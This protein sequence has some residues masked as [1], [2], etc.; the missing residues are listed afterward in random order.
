MNMKIQQGSTLII[1]L[2]VLLLV[3]IVG[4]IAVKS[5]TLGLRLATNN[6]LGQ[7]LMEMND[8]G[9][10]TLENPDP[11]YIE[12]QIAQGGMYSYFNNPS[13]ARNELV[14]CFNTKQAQ[15]YNTS[16]R[17]VIQP[18]GTATGTGYCNADTFSTGRNAVITQVHLAKV[19]STEKGKGMVRGTSIGSTNLPFVAEHLSAVV[20]SLVPGFS[21]GDFIECFKLSASPQ[22]EVKEKRYSKKETIQE[23]LARNNVPFN[24]QYM[25]FKVGNEPRLIVKK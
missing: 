18:N 11:N 8:S 25:E 16:A 23:C 12:K 10:F 17:G 1:V 19:Q 24:A 22:A 20:V 2:V 5:G 4:A 15:A 3:T 21:G 9:F 6:Q 14:F 7:L 13:N